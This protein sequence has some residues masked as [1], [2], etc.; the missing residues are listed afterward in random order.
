M[1]REKYDTQFKEIFQELM[2]QGSKFCMTYKMID[3]YDYTSSYKFN[4]VRRSYKMFNKYLNT[5]GW[6]YYI[7]EVVGCET[8]GLRHFCLRFAIRI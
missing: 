1:N 5:Y 3:Y 7:I 6:Q 8:F 2:V 4:N